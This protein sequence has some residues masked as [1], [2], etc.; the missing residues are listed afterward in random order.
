MLCK[1]GYFLVDTDCRP[2]LSQCL[3]LHV[4]NNLINFYHVL[5]LI[6][7]YSRMIV[8]VNQVIIQINTR[9]VYNVKYLVKLVYLIKIFVH[10]VKIIFNLLK[11]NVY[12]QRN[13]IILIQIANPVIKTVIN[14]I[15]IM[16]VLNVQINIIYIILNVLNVKFHVYNV[17]IFILVYHV[18]IIIQQIIKENVLNV[19][20][21]VNIVL[22]LLIVL[23]V[24]MNSIM[25]INYVSHVLI[26]VQ[27]VKI[28]VNFVH[29]VKILIMYQI[30]K[31]VLVIILTIL[32]IN[33]MMIL[34]SKYQYFKILDAMKI[35]FQQITNVLINVEM[36]FLMNN[37]NNVMME[38]KLEE[39]DVHLFVYKKI[40]IIAK[41][42][43]TLL[44]FVHLFNLQISNQM[45][46]PIN[47]IKLKLLN[48]VSHKELK[49]QLIQI[50]KKL[51]QY[52]FYHKLML[53][54]IQQL[55][56]VYQLNLIIQFIRFLLSLQ[57]LLKMLFQK[58]ILLNQLSK[59]NMIQIQQDIRCK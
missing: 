25:L 27:H 43:Q 47:K 30:N 37:M 56:Q 41:I 16:N 52:L 34:Q 59:M 53:I 8:N 58:Q 29:P 39:M 20:R 14:V 50:L 15:P 3:T 33:I 22:I 49:Y 26:Y 44:V 4:L 7:F 51:Q 31:H 36:E 45:F 55:Q 48:Q 17:R 24:L 28:I 6:I 21:I 19:Y 2:C 32:E 1:Q 23:S 38:I 42:K 54:S 40:S 35:N 5:I 46:S 12:K 18:L 57:A 10:L 11:D 13:I 9:I